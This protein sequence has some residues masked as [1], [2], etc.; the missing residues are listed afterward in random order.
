MRKY[1]AE[2]REIDIAKRVL[3]TE[4]EGLQAMLSIIDYNFVEVV[5][6][7]S[8]IKGRVIVTGVG[9]SGIIAKKFVATL[10]SST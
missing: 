9:K 8:D 2:K 4:I 5:H 6:S 10:A 3:S 7:I 1:M